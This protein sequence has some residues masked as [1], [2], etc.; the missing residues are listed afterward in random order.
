VPLSAYG[1]GDTVAYRVHDL[2]GVD[3]AF[4]I[5]K[6]SVSVDTNTVEQVKLEFV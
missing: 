2:L 6:R 4:R 5:R 3:G 1:V